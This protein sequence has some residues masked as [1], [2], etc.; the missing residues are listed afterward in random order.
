MLCGKLFK[1]PLLHAAPH[2]DRM[3]FVSMG[4]I[5]LINS[6]SPEDVSNLQNY[7]KF[8]RSPTPL[9]SHIAITSSFIIISGDPENTLPQHY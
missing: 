8:S 4:H 2:C 7:V 6:P 1:S 3:C 9:I 5:T